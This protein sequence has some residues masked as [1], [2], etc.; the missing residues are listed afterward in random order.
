MVDAAARC[1]AARGISGLRMRD[2]ADEAGLNIATVH[3]YVPSKAELIQLV[4]TRAHE[5]FAALATPPAGLAPRKAIESHLKAV[6]AIVEQDPAL[7][8]L[9]AEVAVEAA[10]DPAVADIVTAAE[11]AWRRALHQILAAV[12]ISRRRQASALIMLTVQGACLQPTEHRTVR[13]AQQAL[14]ATVTAMIGESR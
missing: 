3:Y 7:A 11:A 14:V 4:V 5:Q 10:H 8:R 13:E 12:P 1:I 9:L 2:V 6:F